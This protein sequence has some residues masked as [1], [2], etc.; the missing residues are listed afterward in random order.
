MLKHYF[1]QVYFVVIKVLIKF[2][3]SI[4]M[5][6][7]KMKNKIIIILQLLFSFIDFLKYELLSLIS[8]TK[9]K[10]LKTSLNGM[11]NA[12]NKFNYFKTTK[13]T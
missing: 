7:F 12:W 4:V 8:E 3:P 13:S 6:I 10:V 5:K 11:F 9:T 2:S 1:F